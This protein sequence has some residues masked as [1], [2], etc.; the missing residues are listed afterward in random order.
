MNETYHE[1]E[2]R[3]GCTDEEFEKYG[4]EVLVTWRDWVGLREKLAEMRE[5][6]DRTLA[7]TPGMLDGYRYGLW[8]AMREMDETQP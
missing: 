1:P 3:A 4:D 5:E 2:R 7:S 6:A 8:E